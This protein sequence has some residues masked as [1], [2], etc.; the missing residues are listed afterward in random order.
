MKL[1]TQTKKEHILNAIYAVWKDADK[2]FA[3]NPTDR[4]NY[5]RYAAMMDLLQMV[6]IYEKE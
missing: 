2:G 1:T 5:G 4:Y 6:K 3:K